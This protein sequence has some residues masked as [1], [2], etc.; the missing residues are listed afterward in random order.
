MIKITLLVVGGLSLL[1]VLIFGGN[2]CSYVTT[3]AERVR[4]SVRESVPIE[5][6]IDRARKMVRDLVP[7]IR[8][9]MHVIAKEEV[10]VERLE[11]HVDGASQSISK[12]R[13]EIQQ[14]TVALK[15]DRSMYHFAGRHYTSDQVKSDLTRRFA[16]YKTSDATLESHRNMLVARQRNLDAAR[17]KLDGMLAAKRQLEVDVENL[18]ARMKLVQV[19]QASSEYNFDDS[20]LARVKDLVAD[21]RSRLAVAE[22]LVNADVK[23]HDEIQLEEIDTAK[24]RDE[25]TEYFGWERPIVAN[26]AQASH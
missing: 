5:F 25:V 24:I 20:Q 2:V 4:D 9:C 12:A 19:A 1:G 8:R 17:L 13:Q 22:K 18:E 11:K 23:Y 21:V 6:E 15:D 7:D 16:R 3:S 26:L 10:E 14:L